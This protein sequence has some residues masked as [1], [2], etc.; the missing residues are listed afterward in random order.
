M[1]A[2]TRGLRHHHPELFSDELGPL[3]DNYLDDIWFLADTGEKNRLQFVIAE[4]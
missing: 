1:K 2:F 4:F 3:V